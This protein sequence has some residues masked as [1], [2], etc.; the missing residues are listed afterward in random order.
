VS[1]GRPLLK[2]V[3]ENGSRIDRPE[4]LDTLR[5]RCARGLTHLPERLRSLEPGP[6][7]YRVEISTELQGL[8]KRMEAQRR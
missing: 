6:T 3:M 4:S 1:G 8:L 2:K 7:D 5:G